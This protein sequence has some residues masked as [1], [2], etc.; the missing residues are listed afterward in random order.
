MRILVVDD[1]SFMRS[2]IGDILVSGGYTLAGEARDGV[3]CLEI[4]PRE[5]PDLVLLDIAMPRMDG[6]SCLQQ[7]KKNHPQA[8]VVMCSSL[9][10][11]E[12][13]IQAIRFG[14]RDFVV[15]PFQKKRLLSAVAMALK[16]YE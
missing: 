15:K 13:I 7:L 8:R 2:I 3:E 5:K 9:G 16:D 12:R 10:D 14:A 1:L 6:L 11:Q 4:Y